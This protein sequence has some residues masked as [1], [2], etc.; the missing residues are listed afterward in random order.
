M[1]GRIF[2]TLALL[3]LPTIA[4][5]ADAGSG[6]TNGA[7]STKDGGNGLAPGAKPDT[8]TTDLKGMG[9]TGSKADTMSPPSRDRAKEGEESS[10]MKPEKTP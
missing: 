1:N 6:P 10:K 9:A 8:S 2:G 4:Y 5:A 7:T 3:M